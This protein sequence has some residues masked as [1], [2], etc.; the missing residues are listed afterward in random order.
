MEGNK[1]IIYLASP[2]GFTDAGRDFMKTVMIPSIK[3]DV[4]LIL[5]PWDSF[6]SISREVE[7]VNSIND[8][9]K[10]KQLLRDLNERIGLNNEESIR[11]AEIIVAILDGSDI[12]SGVAAEIGYAY[13]LNKRIIGYRSDFRQTGDNPAAVVNVQVEHF[14]NKSGG[15][16]VTKI[17]ELRQALVEAKKK[18][19]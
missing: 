9:L 3:K 16:I 17:S 19:P 8:I 10:Q 12:D 13:A 7:K 4:G 15:K 2:Y 11:K 18:R 14:I 6:D 5:N 1:S